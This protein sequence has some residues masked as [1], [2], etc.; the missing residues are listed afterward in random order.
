MPGLAHPRLK[1]LKLLDAIER[2]GDR[3]TA[4]IM[5][6]EAGG[7]KGYE[8]YFGENGA[9][10]RIYKTNPI[11][12]TRQTEFVEQALVEIWEE[13][14]KK[15]H[16]RTELGKRV[17]AWLRDW[18]YLIGPYSETRGGKLRKDSSSR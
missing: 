15:L 13:D 18:I 1:M 4:T 11:P 7:P 12:I 5:Q 2:L 6:A 8:D 14:G 9:L 3:A 16:R 10:T 17:Q